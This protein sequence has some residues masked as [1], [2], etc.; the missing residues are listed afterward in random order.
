MGSS[1]ALKS[2]PFLLFSFFNET[3]Y[4]HRVVTLLALSLPS[5]SKRE[6]QKKKKYEMMH[7]SGFVC[8]IIYTKRAFS[9]GYAARQVVPKKDK[10]IKMNRHIWSFYL[11]VDDK[12]KKKRQTGHHQTMDNWQTRHL[13]RLYDRKSKPVEERL[14]QS[15]D[16]FTSSISIVF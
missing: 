9:C 4:I 1:A 8:I 7:P 11:K 10:S 14:D 16:K 15:R 2:V 3:G 13:N 6:S 12:L 5:F